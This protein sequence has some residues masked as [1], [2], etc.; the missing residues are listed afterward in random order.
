M[1]TGLD[2]R[3]LLQSKSWLKDRKQKVR[4]NWAFY[5]QRKI[6]EPVLF[7][8]FIG[9]IVKE[10]HSEISRFTDCTKLFQSVKS[11]ADGE[12]SQKDH[13]KLN[14]QTGVS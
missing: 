8:I 9:E 11:Y 13:T 14:G 1:A 6:L 3:F 12:G 7:N 4:L 5:F 10:I 2:E